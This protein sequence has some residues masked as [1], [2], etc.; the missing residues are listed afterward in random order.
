MLLSNKFTKADLFLNLH[1]YDVL[2]Q[3]TRKIWKDTFNLTTKPVTPCELMLAIW[4]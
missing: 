2:I 4:L 1:D 3:A